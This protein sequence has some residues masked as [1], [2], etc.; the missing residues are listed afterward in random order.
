MAVILIP[1][2]QPNQ[3]QINM[4]TANHKKAH[5]GCGLTQVLTGALFCALVSTTNAQTLTHRWSF[6]GTNDS[7]GS[8]GV[9]LVGGASISSGALNVFGAPTAGDYGSVDISSDFTNYTSTTIEGWFTEAAIQDWSKAWMFGNGGV[10]ANAGTTYLDFTPNRG[11]TQ[12][13]GISITPAPFAGGDFAVAGPAKLSAG[14]EHHAVAVYDYAANTMTLYINGAFNCSGSMQNTPIS[15]LKATQF[16]FGAGTSWPD[17]SMNGSFNE[18]RVYNGPLTPAQVEADYEAGPDS[19][20]GVPGALS[21]IEFNNPTN[22]LVEGKFAPVILASYAALTNKVNITAVSGISYSSDDTNVISYG[23]DGLFHAVAIGTTTIRASYQ[24]LAAALTVTVSLEPAVVVHRYSFDGAPGTADITD[25]VGGATGTLVNGT[26]TATLT[27]SGQLNLDG[28]PSSAYVSLP[29]GIIS[30]LTNAT[31]QTWVNNHD[32]FADWAELWA[33]GT[34]NGIQ[35]VSYITLIPNN[36]VSGKLRLDFHGILDAPSSLALSNDSCVTVTYNYSAQLASIFVDGRKVATGTFTT[37]LYTLPDANNYIGQ[38]QWY[39]S[40]DPYFNGVLDELRIYSGVESDFQIAVDAATGPNLIV[41]NVGALQSVTVTT[42]NATVDAHGTSVPIKVTAN[43]ANVSGVDVTTLADT[44]L[45]NS[46]NSVGT[47]AS[48]NFAPKN[49]GVS[50]VTATYQGV[51]GSVAFTV[52]DPEAWPALLHRYTFNETSGTTINDSVGSINGTINGPVTL[53]G[54][55]LV[56]PAGNPPPDGA[57]LPTAA[58]G[59]VSYPAGLGLVTGLP[60]QASIESWVTW[61]GGGVWQEMFDF[62]QAA[63]PGVSLGGGNYVMVS[64]HD[65]ISGSLRMEWFPGG[66]VLTGPSLQQGVL[67]QVVIT[68]DQDRQLDKLYLNGQLIASGQ[69]NRLWSSLSDADNWLARDQWPDPMFN[70]SYADMRFWNGALTAG[71]VA[72]LYAAGPDVIAGPALQI[73]LAGSQVTLK[74]PAN[75]T[76]FTLQSTTTLSGGTWNP[77]SGTPTVVNGLNTL[78]LSASQAQTYYRLKE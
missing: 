78:T 67:S 66:L 41:T 63:T 46:D 29:A 65:G 43:F 10:N 6:D 71:Q 22:T 47:L 53:T 49:V 42:P 45:S 37:P 52:V 44:I 19:I 68:H 15:A 35:G 18:I 36:P 14:I 64:P 3:R 27:G 20:S 48:G 5:S 51:S 17:A 76:T 7:V 32:V 39:G 8:A 26:G 1:D 12:S 58:S 75:A 69:N 70:G 4:K 2:S 13:P 77:V 9:T 54:S 59:W 25:S 16:R 62:G 73:S 33:F 55:A 72:N 57:G 23:T 61:A 60:N 56:M 11:A 40:G 38:S 50:T 74:W 34:N 24:S 31:I 30:P 28:N 21:S